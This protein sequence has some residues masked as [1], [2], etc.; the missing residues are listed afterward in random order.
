MSITHRP[1]M[2]FILSTAMC[3]SL[4]AALLLPGAAHAESLR[5]GG[6]GS[7]LGTMKLLAEGYR[8]LDP[9]FVLEIVPNLGSSGGIAAL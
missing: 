3:L 9:S 5:L 4:G 7:A 2:N 6:T 8:K 1:P